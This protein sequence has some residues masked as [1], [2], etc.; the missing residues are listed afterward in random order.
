MAIWL[1]STPADYLSTAELKNSPRLFHR[2]ECLP[3]LLFFAS[4]GHGPAQPMRRV[5]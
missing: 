5:R 2:I 4:A 1:A 3:A